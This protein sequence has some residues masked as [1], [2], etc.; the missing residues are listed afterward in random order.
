MSTLK[1]QS[2][3]PRRRRA[4]GVVAGVAVAALTLLPGIV[5]A[6]PPAVAAKSVNLRAGPGRDYPLV[7]R[8]GPGTPLAVQGC[9]DGYAWCD[10]VV[11]GNY[12]GWVYAGNISYAYQQERVPLLQYGAVIGLPI[13]GFSL[14]SYWG[15]Y[16]RNRP[17]Y[18]DRGRW[19]HRPMPDRRVYAGPPPGVGRPGFGGRPP[20]VDGRF[21]GPGRGAEGER[22][23][24]EAGFPP[25]GRGGE[26]GPRS[27]VGR[28]G[29]GRPDDGRLESGHPEGARP[30]VGRADDGRLPSGRPEGIRQEG[31]RPDGGPRGGGRPDGDRGDRGDRGGRGRP[32]GDQGGGRPGGDQG[33]GRGEGRPGH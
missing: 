1:H 24:G 23:R 10:V 18:R 28:P 6:Q 31:G 4:L 2:R 19:E 27:D 7:L 8:V 30:N 5:E 26:R 14:G 32:G 29:G 25:F 9:V 12:R 33:G 15:D 16:Y 22:H 20:V 13:I 3:Y 17:F 21:G 11:P